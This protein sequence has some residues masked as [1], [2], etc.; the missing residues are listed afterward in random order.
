MIV[1]PITAAL[2]SNHPL[3][4]ARYAS[5]RPAGPWPAAAGIP[6]AGKLS[7]PPLFA[8]LAGTSAVPHHG[9]FQARGPSCRARWP[10]AR[11]ASFLPACIKADADRWS[12]LPATARPGS[13]PRDRH[14][15]G[16]VTRWKKCALFF[17]F[18]EADRYAR[19]TLPKL[20]SL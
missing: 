7:R 6:R 9:P 19:L 2:K 11:S 16:Q 12:H 20:K 17:L 18:A 8:V 14:R 5:R 10:R 1:P 15:G 3:I 13:R 4:S